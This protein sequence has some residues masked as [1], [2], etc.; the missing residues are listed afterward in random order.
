MEKDDIAPPMPKGFYF[1]WSDEL[2]KYRFRPRDTMDAAAEAFKQAE[3][4]AEW[5]NAP[6]GPRE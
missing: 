3:T 2:G 6:N 1:Y 4:F 5:L